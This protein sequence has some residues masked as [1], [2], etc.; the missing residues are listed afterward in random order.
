MDKKNSRG[1]RESVF[2]PKKEW[3]EEKEKRVAMYI[4]FLLS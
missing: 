3:E 1:E 4:V 2:P